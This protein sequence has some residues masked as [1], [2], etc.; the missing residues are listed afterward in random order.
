MSLLREK[1]SPDCVTKHNR[2]LQSY[3]VKSVADIVQPIVSYLNLILLCC[4]SS[5]VVMMGATVLATV[6]RWGPRYWQ[7]LREVLSGVDNEGKPRHWS[8]DYYLTCVHND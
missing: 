6:G 2:H 5:C 3:C 8:R 1:I 7:L 4:S